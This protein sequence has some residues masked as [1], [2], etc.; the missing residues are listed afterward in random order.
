MPGIDIN[1]APYEEIE[2]P[3]W[4]VPDAVLFAL[5]F[6]GAYLAVT[7]HLNSIQERIDVHNQNAQNAQSKLENL[8][9]DLAIVTNLEKETLE[10]IKDSLEKITVS[11]LAKYLP[12]ILIEHIQLLKPDGVWLTKVRL[13]YG[14]KV[15]EEEEDDN[16]KKNQNN[17]PAKQVVLENILVLEGGAVSNTVLAEFLNHLKATEQQEVDVDDIRTKVFFE[18]LEID[19]VQLEA[20]S[21]EDGDDRQFDAVTYSVFG[22]FGEREDVGVPASE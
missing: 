13:D 10:Q 2:Q 14:V 5:V 3:F 22:S 6:I 16:Q 21:I 1:L 8:K 18:D 9:S 11:K 12:I 20:E 19:T 15:G 7:S 4:W 17:E